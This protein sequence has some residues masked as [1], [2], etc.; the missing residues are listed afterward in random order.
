MDI[1]KVTLS[2]NDGKEFSI[3][4]DNILISQLISSMITEC[5]N[6]NETIPLPNVNSSSLEKI[7]EFCNHYT[8]N[9][10]FNEIEKPLRS[11]KMEDVIPPWYA[12]FVD[13]MEMELLFE[14]VKGANYMAIKPLLDL[15][16]A[17]IASMIKGKSPE[18][19]RET[20]GIEN[21]FTP[22]EEARLREEHKW[23][24]DIS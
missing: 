6:I 15:C 14:V 17:K 10:D 9:N 8:E 13:S 5:S 12:S 16:C 2:S 20:F 22:E 23:C 19:I 11:S 3:S 7:I 21:D 4:K 24:D 1:D 18:E